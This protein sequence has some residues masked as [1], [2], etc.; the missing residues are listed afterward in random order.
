MAVL[1]LAASSYISKSWP[2]RVS[3]ADSRSAGP[4]TGKRQQVSTADPPFRDIGW[5]LSADH[6]C[7]SA[8]ST[9]TELL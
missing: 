7:A 8:I 5:G 9:P 3:F 2:R 6:R 1:S 4:E